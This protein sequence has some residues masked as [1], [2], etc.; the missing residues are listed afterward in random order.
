[1]RAHQAVYPVAT[2]C[3]VLRVS[4]SGYYAWRLRGPSARARADAALLADLR[5][6]H[7]RS[8][9]TYGAPRLL[10]DLRDGGSSPSTCSWWWSLAFCSIPSPPGTPG[11]RP[12]PSM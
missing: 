8:D 10:Q 12:A 7:Q 9:G 5:A 3:R 11:R 1:M 6:Y 4:P 2:M